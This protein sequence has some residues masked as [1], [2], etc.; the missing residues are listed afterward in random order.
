MKP[1]TLSPRVAAFLAW[2]AVAASAVAW[3]LAAV[4]PAPPAAWPPVVAPG[5]SPEAGLQR[6]WAAPPASPAGPVAAGP[7]AAPPDPGLPALLGVLARGG[8]GVALFAAGE[9]PPRAL[10]PGEPLQDGWRLGRLEP[11]AAWIEHEDG[12]RQ[13]LAL[14]DPA[15]AG[16]AAAPVPGAAPAPGGWPLPAAPPA[17]VPPGGP[18]A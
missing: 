5:P 15:A 4:R 17:L 13:R 10:R 2:A 7:A 16:P 18:P 1:L 9:R 8:G 11:R 6:L 14:P 3:T 12:R